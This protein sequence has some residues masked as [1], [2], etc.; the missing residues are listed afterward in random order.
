[1]F[2]KEYTLY[3]VLLKILNILTINELV[4][5][6]GIILFL[7]LISLYMNI[8][9]LQFLLISVLIFLILYMAQLKQNH[10]DDLQKST[11]LTE[12]NNMSLLKFI[13]GVSYFNLYNKPIYDDFMFKT[14]QYI[15]LL[16]LADIHKKNEYKLYSKKVIKENLDSQKQDILET[17]ASFEH[18]LDD[19]ITSAYKL[20]DLTNQ[21]N[22]ILTK[23]NLV[24]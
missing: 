3:D 11:K 2:E 7:G 23:S 24:I 6:I 22:T 9:L 5:W 18:T 19:R 13:D 17:F 14:K 21:L 1:M 20:R 15:K 12:T 16:K 10:T 4:I 8:S